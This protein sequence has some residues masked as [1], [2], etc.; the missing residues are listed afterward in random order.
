MERLDRLERA[1]SLGYKYNPQTGIITGIRGTEITLKN[2]KG[3]IRFDLYV[4]GK[5][6]NVYGHHFAYYF[7][8]SECPYEI[9]HINRDRS[10]NRIENLRGVTRTENQ[11]NRNPKGYSYNK[12]EKK[13]QAQ[14]K[15]NS[16]SIHLGWFK[17][18]DDARK[19]YL[20]AKVK[21]HKTSV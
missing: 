19:A 8:Y 2:N 3:Y 14:I 18:E 17:E 13:F 7:V 15:V 21:Y 4:N 9:D 10:D 5:S 1:V 11:H 12:K 20:E 16:K 6:Y